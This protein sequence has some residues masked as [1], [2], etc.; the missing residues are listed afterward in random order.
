MLGL[1]RVWNAVEYYFPYLDLMDENWHDLLPEYISQMLNANDRH[2]YDLIL[3]SMTA[4]LRDPHV[5][6]TDT[7]SITE[8]LGEY[9]I[10]VNLMMIEGYPV[11]VDI[12]RKI[13]SCK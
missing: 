8:E 5:S 9:L 2:S 1:F 6:F 11:V 12:F 10:P 7:E 3:A 13:V 4:K